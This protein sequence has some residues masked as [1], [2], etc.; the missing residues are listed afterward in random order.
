MDDGPGGSHLRSGQRRFGNKLES[1]QGSLGLN[2]LGRLP[3]PDSAI[4]FECPVCRSREVADHRHGRSVSDKTGMGARSV[5]LPWARQ[6]TRRMQDPGP[7][8][9]R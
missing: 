7:A 3:A 2:C 6:E 1:G 5:A 4:S 9:P 8:S